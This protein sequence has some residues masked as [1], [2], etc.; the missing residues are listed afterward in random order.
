MKNRNY[1]WKKREQAIFLLRLG[2]LLS[3]GYHLSNAIKFLQAQEPEGRREKLQEAVDGLRAGK[4]LYEVLDSMQFYRPLLQFVHYAQYYGD[5]P[6]AL[7]EGGGYWRK[8][9]DDQSKLVKTLLY[10]LFLFVLVAFTFIMLQGILLPKFEALYESMNIEPGFF[11]QTILFF[12]SITPYFFLSALGIFIFGTIL[13]KR[14]Y[15]RL[16]P[17]E[18]KII[19]LK[20]PFVGAFIRMYETYYLSFQLSGLLGGGLSINETMRLFSEHNQQAFYRKLGASIFEELNEGHSLEHI[21]RQFPFFEAPFNDVLVNG[22]KN[23]KLDQELFHYS[24]L[25][26]SKLE[27]KTAALIKVV[28]PVLFATVGLIIVTIYLSVLMPMFAIIDGL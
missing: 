11:L 14:W 19:L 28:Q 1:Q 17:F 13:K 9:T 3:S 16:C 15:D 4:S 6:R 2:E 25:I 22:Q 12:S 20:L 18:Q 5:L 7:I 24:R 8:R 23:G 10:P 21:F 27:E 26:L